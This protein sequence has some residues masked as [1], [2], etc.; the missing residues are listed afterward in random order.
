VAYAIRNASARLTRSIHTGVDA[1]LCCSNFVADQIAKGGY[2][3][4]RIHTLYNFADL[5]DA[6]PRTKPGEYVAYIG[7]I[8]PEKGLDVLIAAARISGLPVKIAGDP[9]PMPELQESL[10]PN[11]EFVGSLK[12][13]QIPGFLTNARMLAV[14]SIWYEAFGIVCAE[15]M[16]YRLPVIASDMGGLPEVVTHDATGLCVP[17]R[18]PE[19]LADAMQ[20]LWNDPARA[21]ALG[22]A[23]RE[24]AMREYTPDVYYRRLTSAYRAVLRGKNAVAS[25]GVGSAA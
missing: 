11:V 23:G 13:E 3:A 1:Y 20:S 21:A 25:E 8:S 16:A 15:A 7:R 24:K 6:P 12:R 5:P 10:P 17:P 4:D 9:T 19:R 2:P 18:D 14:P 22:E